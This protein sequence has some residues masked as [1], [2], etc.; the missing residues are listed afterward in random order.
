MLLQNL[1]NN[2]CNCQS[3]SVK[4]T[5]QYNDTVVTCV[6]SQVEDSDDSDNSSAVGGRN[7]N[8]SASNTSNQVHTI[9]F[10]YFIRLFH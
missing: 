7:D 9:L 2:L 3:S 10:V 8:K 5:I 6:L 4:F 1:L